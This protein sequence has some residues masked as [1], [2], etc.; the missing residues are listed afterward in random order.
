MKT[1]DTLPR[2]AKRAVLLVPRDRDGLATIRIGAWLSAGIIGAGML[3]VGA[4]LMVQGANPGLTAF[5]V[6]V[7]GGVIAAF[8]WRTVSHI[9]AS[10]DVP[11]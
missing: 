9:L 6:T 4:L 1:I 11:A 2:Q 10:F 7:A 3:A 5:A 8:S